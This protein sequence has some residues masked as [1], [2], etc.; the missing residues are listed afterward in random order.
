MIPEITRTPGTQ[1]EH[2]RRFVSINT[3]LL[4]PNVTA[5]CTS[6]LVSF[7]QPALVPSLVRAALA[8]AVCDTPTAAGSSRLQ[9]GL[10]VGELDRKT[11]R[12]SDH[13]PVLG[14]AGLLEKCLFQQTQVASCEKV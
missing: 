12:P 14:R 3:V 1:L 11:P 10:S 4:R 7:T 5:P 9:R 6:V 2:R 8:V 13:P